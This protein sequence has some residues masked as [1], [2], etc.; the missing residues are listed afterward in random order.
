M[1]ALAR[2]LRPV[3]P[4]VLT[5]IGVVLAVDAVLLAR[6]HPVAAL[7]TVLLAAL[8]DGL[9]GAVAVVADR[10]SRSGAV[11]DAVADRVAD[12]CFALVL[13]RCGAPLP[14]AGAAAALAVAI[15]GLRRV[16][17]LPARITVGERPTW[18][19]CTVLACGASA[20][21]AADWPVEVC[22]AVWLAA[23]VVGVGQ[24]GRR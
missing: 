18:T 15:D 9:D 22:A 4:T 10:A 16:R 5:V 6:R 19:L 21:S 11:A 20:V 17:R 14:V 8:C 7:V 13:W 24:L 1:W 2:P 12:V 23:G 3:P